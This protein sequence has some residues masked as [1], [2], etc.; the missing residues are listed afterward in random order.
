MCS[1]FFTGNYYYF[2][3]VCNKIL[4]KFYYYLDIGYGHADE[5]LYSPV[6]FE[7][8]EL[9]EHY[10]GDYQ[11]MI[12]NYAHAYEN[13]EKIIHEFMRNAYNGGAYLKCVEAYKF[14]K[15][16]PNL[17]L[18]ADYLQQLETY[19]H[20]CLPTSLDQ[21]EFFDIPGREHYRLLE[22]LSLNYKSIIDIGTHRGSSAYSLSY[23]GDNKVHSFDIIDKIGDK[24]R[25][26]SNINFYYDNLWTDDG[27]EK[28]KNLILESA[29]IFL[30]VDPHNGT[31]EFEFYNKLKDNNYKGI[32]LCDDI[33]YFSEMK[34]KFWNLV[35]VS[36]KYDLTKIG[37]WSGTGLILF[38]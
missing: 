31:M 10:F 5:Q 21:R 34:E 27:F 28:H 9:F 32:L 37:H 12:T 13:P 38:K 8:P 11:S 24:S 4:E 26:P 29:C 23:S 35:P 16:T 14:I 36:E 2:S 6:Y 20:L 19:Y 22:T 33:H 15:N 25:F 3:S 30:D 1:G 18:T 7:N 17:N